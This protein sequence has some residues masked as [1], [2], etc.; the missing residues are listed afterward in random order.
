MTMK[1]T[2]EKVI[3][4]RD[5][6]KGTTV[7]TLSAVAGLP[8]NFQNANKKTK[9]ILIRHKD[10]LDSKSQPQAKIIRAGR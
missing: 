1:K 10:A 7:M 5:F 6:M 2:N 3:T 9:V 4:R 8:I